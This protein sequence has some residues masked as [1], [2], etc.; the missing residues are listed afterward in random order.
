MAV[1]PAAFAHHYT[2]AGLYAP[3]VRYWRRVEFTEGFDTVDLNEA[4]APRRVERLIEVAPPAPL[5]H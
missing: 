3:A 4:K 2:E 5:R 1:K